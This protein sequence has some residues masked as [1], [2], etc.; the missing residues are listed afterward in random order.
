MSGL[1]SLPLPHD[2]PADENAGTAFV[3]RPKYVRAWRWSPEFADGRLRAEPGSYRVRENLDD[4]YGPTRDEW[5]HPSGV[6]TPDNG[7]PSHVLT[8]IG[9]EHPANGDVIVQHEDGTRGVYKPAA[10]IEEYEPA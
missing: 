10:F 4:E 5:C 6:I 3:T 8:R 2:G 9:R 1:L 7:N